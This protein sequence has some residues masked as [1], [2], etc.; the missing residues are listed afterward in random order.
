MRRFPS[1]E[2]RVLAS[3]RGVAQERLPATRISAG[4]SELRHLLRRLATSYSW[5]PFVV[6]LIGYTVVEVVYHRGE[7]GKWDVLNLSAWATLAAGMAIAQTIPERLRRTLL[8]LVDR[9]ALEASEGRI[10][11]VF[12]TACERAAAWGRRVGLIVAVAIGLAFLVAFPA[13]LASRIV[14][15]TLA[16]VGAYI[17]GFQLGRM[18]SFGRVGTILDQAGARIH[19]EPAHPDGVGGLK[20][21]GEFFLFQAM[22]AGIPAVFLAGWLVLFPLLGD[23]YE[24]WRRPYPV[25]L[26]IAIVL[27]LL[28]F[29]VPM[30]FFHRRMEE[31]KM[32]AD[33]LS[34]EIASLSRR[35]ATAQGDEAKGVK[36]RLATLNEQYAA[37]E[38]MPTWPVDVRTRRRF[39]LN[40][41]A[42][43]LPLV[44]KLVGSSPL[45][46]DVADVLRGLGD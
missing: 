14:L 5:A 38:S 45:W 20:P 43:F 22:V 33:R 6:V 28:A 7:L 17:A 26:A 46:K 36:E 15:V 10:A 21:I 24:H 30:L 11:E 42:L 37:L 41:V 16:L 1:P 34:G 19:L 2:R 8:R 3:V 32:E 13:G 9:G 39:R 40:N 27:E 25:L 31:K 35:V 4:T 44:G 12:E 18:A 29:F 23:R